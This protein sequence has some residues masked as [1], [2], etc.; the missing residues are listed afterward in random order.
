MEKI[1]NVI[2]EYILR[3]ISELKGGLLELETNLT[4]ADAE[5]WGLWRDNISKWEALAVKRG[6]TSQYLNVA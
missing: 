5:T 3:I 4:L 2:G 6:L 1:D